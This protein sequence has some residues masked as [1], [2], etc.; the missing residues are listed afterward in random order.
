MSEYSPESDIRPLEP[1]ATPA[2]H[3]DPLPFDAPSTT[4]DESNAYTLSDADF[5]LD[6]PPAPAEPEIPKTPGPGLPEAIGWMLGVF[7]LQ[8]VGA[9]V[10]GLVIVGLH[11]AE[12][13]TLD[14]LR[15]KETLQRLNNDNLGLTFTVTQVVSLM[16]IMLATR[17]RLGRERKRRLPLRPIAWKHLLAIFLAMIP[18][19]SLAVQMSIVGNEAWDSIAEAVPVLKELDKVSSQKAVEKMGKQ[20]TFGMMIFLVAVCPAISEEL[21]FRGVIGR[22]LIAR[23]G[24]PAGI[25]MTSLLF[26]AMHL[27]P[28]HVFALLPLSVFLHVTY[29]TTR[30]FWAPMLVHFLNNSVAVIFLAIA[31]A[32]PEEM[33]QQG[34]AVAPSFSP[35]IAFGSLV[36][37]GLLISFLW[38]TRVQYYRSDGSVW[39]PGYATAEAPPGNDH[40]EPYCTETID[41]REWAMLGGGIFIFLLCLILPL[42]F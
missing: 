4:L 42:I 34:E 36:C 16:G 7:L 12:G 23:W 5:N 2:V 41:G 40:A 32:M 6:S 1:P 9:F 38:H 8:I 39:D 13:G 27:H 18:L 17:L 20:L 26:A 11:F 30:S 21:V 19:L 24:L 14:G 37:V 28:P 35:A 25:A 33:K 10:A 31:L 3:S 15:N 29:H 22:G